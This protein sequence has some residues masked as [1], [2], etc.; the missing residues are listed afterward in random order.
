[1]HLYEDVEL[2]LVHLLSKRGFLQLTPVINIIQGTL[3]AYLASPGLLIGVDLV[4][5][6]HSLDGLNIHSLIMKLIV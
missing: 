5:H 2:F 4:R 6:F 3:R 1:M